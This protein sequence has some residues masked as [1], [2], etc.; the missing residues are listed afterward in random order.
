MT[1]PS[2]KSAELKLFEV[3]RKKLGNNHGFYSDGVVNEDEFRKSKK[4]ILF[5]LKEVNSGNSKEGGC[6]IEF[7]SKG[8]PGG[9]WK[10][11]ND[12]ARWTKGLRRYFESKEIINFTEV[13][14]VDVES[15]KELLSHIAAM[16]LD[17]TGGGG[18]ADWEDIRQAKE[19]DWAEIKKQMALYQA[20]IVVCCG[21]FGLIEELAEN[22]AIKQTN[23]G[24]RFFET[25]LSFG[26]D[27]RTVFIDHCHPAARIKKQYKL[28]TLLDAVAKIFPS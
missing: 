15:R 25:S 11:W 28:Y 24:V 23:R 26:G 5:L 14:H 7:L 21:T 10:T 17:K 4:R 13:D 27:K 2:I 9:G 19:R 8:A 22:D 1:I 20:D 12:I 18:T 3:W 16:N 6:L